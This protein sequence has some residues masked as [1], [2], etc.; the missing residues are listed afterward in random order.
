MDDIDTERTSN[1]NQI[2]DHCLSKAVKAG[3]LKKNVN[4][5]WC[6]GRKLRSLGLGV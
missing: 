3:L 1:G 4:L 5:V 6:G 2:A